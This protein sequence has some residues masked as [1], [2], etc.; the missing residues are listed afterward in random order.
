VPLGAWLRGELRE[1][2]EA[3][4]EPDM[5]KRDGYLNVDLVTKMWKEHQQGVA[6]WHFQLW[7]ILIFQNWLRSQNSGS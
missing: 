1:W 2:G 7:N 5:L 6:D 4:I 3:L